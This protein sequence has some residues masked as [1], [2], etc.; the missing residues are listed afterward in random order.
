VTTEWDASGPDP[1]AGYTNGVWHPPAEVKDERP[2]PERV[3]GFNILASHE[4][5]APLPPIAWLCEGLFIAPG[6]PVMFA[7]YSYSG[8]SVAVQSLGLGIASGRLI[9]GKFGARKGRV[10]H[11]DYEQG[12]RL[13]RSRYQRMAVHLKAHPDE[14]DGRLELGILPSVPLTLDALKRLGE[15]R[16]LVLVDAWRGAH[17]N[18]EENSSD[19]RPSLDAM[20]R[21]SEETGAVFG[22]LHHAKKPT[23]NGSNEHKFSIRGSSGFA[24]G[25]Q[26]IYV[27]DGT[28]IGRPSVHLVKDRMLGSKIEPF[29]LLI[30]DTRGYAGLSVT[31]AE[32]AGASEESPVD[33]FSKT[34]AAVLEHVRKDAT[35]TASKFAEIT[36]KGKGH[37]VAVY[38]SLLS[39]GEVI[40][41]GKTTSVRYY[42]RGCVP[43][44]P[45]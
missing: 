34:S 37:V 43:D 20:T 17:P 9:W 2:D 24:D 31:Y 3:A 19:V 5:F 23:E 7:G 36:G 22:T 38:Q 15:G 6:A 29:D 25:C 12:A 42:V 45:F 26:T 10:L 14:I 18:V 32:S 41:V 44:A 4:I 28:V 1:D 33:K 27:L 35:M 11:L 30:E 8:K 13:S 16:D 40:Q 21:A 39:S